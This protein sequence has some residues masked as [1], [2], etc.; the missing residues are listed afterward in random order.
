MLS[1]Q[2]W[3]ELCKTAVATGYMVC[4][5][6]GVNVQIEETA[7]RRNGTSAQ[8]FGNNKNTSIKSSVK[9]FKMYVGLR[10]ENTEFELIYCQKNTAELHRIQMAMVI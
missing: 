2:P 9:T 8:R 7:Q 1:M 4:L 10:G 5:S 3:F 6:C